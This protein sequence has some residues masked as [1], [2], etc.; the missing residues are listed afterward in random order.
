[1][2]EVGSATRQLIMEILHELK[3]TAGPVMEFGN[4]EAIKQAVIHGGGVAWLPSVSI[5]N[6][7]HSG[8]LVQLASDQLMIRRPLSVIRRSSSPDSPADEA[9]IKNAHAARPHVQLPAGGGK[10]GKHV[11]CLIIDRGRPVIE[12]GGL[13]SN[14][15]HWSGSLQSDTPQCCLPGARALVA[16]LGTANKINII[17]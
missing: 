9:F 15:V 12:L 14:T 6:E 13:S 4:T 10:R 8:A 17:L 7:L 1:M 3:I 5:S 2:R 11:C 16:T